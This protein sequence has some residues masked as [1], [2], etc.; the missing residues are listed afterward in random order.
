MTKTRHYVYYLHDDVRSIVYV[1]AVWGA[2]KTGDPT[3]VDPRR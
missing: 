2:P 1:I 3:I